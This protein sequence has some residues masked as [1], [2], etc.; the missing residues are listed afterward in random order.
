MYK[1]KMPSYVVGN[2][3]GDIKVMNMPTIL[4]CVQPFSEGSVVEIERISRTHERYHLGRENFLFI[5]FKEKRKHEG[6]S[7]AHRDFYRRYRD[8]F[9]PVQFILY[10]FQRGRELHGDIVQANFGAFNFDEL[11]LEIPY[12]QTIHD[13]IKQLTV[14]IL[15]ELVR[16][17]PTHTS[18]T[19][20]FLVDPVLQRDPRN[21]GRKSVLEYLGI[22]VKKEYAPA[23]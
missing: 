19:E 7:H 9:E 20:L 5:T 11:R 12:F 3:D 8:T 1:T 4:K 17:A 10:I 21:L 2:I 16:Y 14:N 15:T 22:P 18:V 13:E 23:R 6:Y